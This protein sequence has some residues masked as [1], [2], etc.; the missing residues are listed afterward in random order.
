MTNLYVSYN[1]DFGGGHKMLLSWLNESKKRK[2]DTLTLIRP[3]SKL[4]KYLI[5][6]EHNFLEV[7]LGE[8][9]K[10]K[11]LMYNVLSRFKSAIIVYS[12]IKKFNVN[13]IHAIDTFSY[14]AILLPGIFL[15]KKIIWTIQDNTKINILIRFVLIFFCKKVILCANILKKEFNFFLNY[16]IKV[17]TNGVNIK[18]LHLKELKEKLEY[19]QKNKKLKLGFIGRLDENKNVKQIINAVSMLKL[20]NY[21]FELLIVGNGTEEKNLYALTKKLDL[22]K[23]I[24]FIGWVEKP[25]LF[26][27]QID[28][29]IQVSKSEA[30]SLSILEALHFGLPCIV[31]N[32]GDNKVLIEN[33]HNGYFT[34]IDNH[35]DTAKHIMKLYDNRELLKNFSYISLQKSSSFSYKMMIEKYFKLYEAL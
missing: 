8:I 6:Y 26:Y 17:I 11:S 31:T 20:A 12:K 23:D 33:N 29:F 7:D 25:Q 5:S 14:I 28:L 21:D 18:G 10:R 19:S 2:I 24:K 4:K 27:K 13:I 30:F 32:V 9:N 35:Y 16:K 15:G 1:N 34:E 3:K 22:D